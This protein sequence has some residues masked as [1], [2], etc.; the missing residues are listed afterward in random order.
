MTADE[1]NARYDPMT[2]DELIAECEHYRRYS[3][4]MNDILRENERL[5]VALRTVRGR[6]YDLADNTRLTVGTERWQIGQ[7]MKVTLS[8]IDEALGSQSTRG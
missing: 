4:Q 7:D 5:R 8:V 3:L 1:L 6:V 2:R